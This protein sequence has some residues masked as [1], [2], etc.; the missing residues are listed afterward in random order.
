[1]IVDLG[2]MTPED[3]A[4]LG[5]SPELNRRGMDRDAIARC[6]QALLKAECSYCSGAGC[7]R[8]SRGAS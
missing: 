3:W 4:L 5:R 8:C 7:P 2:N 6:A 1:M